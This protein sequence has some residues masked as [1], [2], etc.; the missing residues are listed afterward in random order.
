[1]AESTV[2]IKIQVDADTAAIDRVQARLAALSAQAAATN[3]RLT[4][5]GKTFDNNNKALDKTND[6]LDKTDDRLKKAGK[7]A[8]KFKSALTKLGAILKSITGLLMKG[9]LIN[10]AAVGV[11]IVSVNAAFAV[12]AA[13]VK[14][15]RWSL[16]ALF[17]VLSG[18]GASA[19]AVLSALAAGQREYIAALNASRYGG[20]ASGV[21]NASAQMRG[22]TANTKLAVLGAE[23]L[24]GAFV[25]VSRQTRVTG[26]ITSALT[27]LGDFAASSADPAKSFTA[28]GEFIGQL[29]KEGKLTQQIVEAASEIGPE[30][31]KAVKDA[32]KRG[33]TSSDAFLKALIGGE[34]SKDVAGQLDTINNTLFGTAKRNFQLIKE[35]FA[36]LGQPLL[37]PF[38]EGMER[39]ARIL[40]RSVMQISAATTAFGKGSFFDAMTEGVDKL[41]SWSVKT[42]NEYLPKAE[43]MFGRISKFFRDFQNGWNAALDVIRPLTEGG[44][45]LIDTFGPALSTIFGGFGKGLYEFNDLLKENRD[46]FLEFGEALKTLA[47]EIG[48]LFGVLKKALVDALPTITRVLNLLTEVFAALISVFGGIASMGQFGAVAALAGFGYGYKKLGDIGQTKT[49]KRG[50]GAGRVAAVA[51]LGGNASGGSGLSQSRAPNLPGVT[52]A[53]TVQAKIVYLYGKVIPG[54]GAGPGVGGGGPLPPPAYGGPQYGPPV[55]GPAAQRYARLRAFSGRLAP[56]G[57]MGA[58][59]AMM[60]LPMLADTYSGMGSEGIGNAANL[61]STVGTGSMMMGLG[62][63]KSLGAGGVAYASSLGADYVS[64]LSLGAS[65]GVSGGTFGAIGVGSGAITGA[66][67]GATIGSVVPI[68]G[69]T[70]GAIIGGIAGGITGYMKQGS[71]KKESKQAATDLASNYDEGIKAAFEARDMSAVELYLKQMREDGKLKAAQVPHQESFNKEFEKNAALIEDEMLPKLKMHN[72]NV[73]LLSRSSGVAADKIEQLARDAGVNLVGSLEDVRKTMKQLGIDVAATSEELKHAISTMFGDAVYDALMGPIDAARALE[74]WDQS[75]QVIQDKIKGGISPTD[76]EMSEFLIT[77]YEYLI[78]SGKSQTEALSTLLENTGEGGLFYESG[79]ALS[80]GEAFQEGFTRLLNDVGRK[81]FSEENIKYFVRGGAENLEANYPG[82]FQPVDVDSA[83]RTVQTNLQS[84]IDSGHL[85]RALGAFGELGQLAEPGSIP[86]KQFEALGINL[87]KVNGIFKFGDLAGSYNRFIERF[88]PQNV[89]QGGDTTSSRLASTLGSHDN[90][91]AQLAGK[92]S[93]TS[94]LRDY[95]LGS[96][97]SDHATG[98]AYDLIGQNLGSYQQL[99]QR[100]GGFAEFHGG[101]ANR[102]LHVVPGATGDTNAPIPSLSMMSTP[103]AGMVQ[104]SYQITINP[105]DNAS[106]R[107]IAEMVMDRIIRENRSARER[108]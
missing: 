99:V 74:A 21:A 32:Q 34:L 105:S 63:K 98:N 46:D 51:G 15:Y 38:T 72:D 40:R 56:M 20:G 16:S 27:A 41:M 9:F 42:F 106:P 18:A 49:G 86:V 93:V 14:A 94:S 2:T 92:R 83:S 52:T 107:E 53:M 58:M 59:L 90:F 91:D 67:I 25:S 77:G 10:L 76:A 48:R 35:Q 104:N 4:D 97:S 78:R 103:S 45:V 85:D 87:E 64:G 54:R 71:L 30:F 19:V 75:S 39:V 1:M 33:L 11:A 12:G 84:L 73:K 13:A 68:I 62:V 101:S 6:Q 80:G 69:T 8:D 95:N 50:R 61:A 22:L 96:M 44:S 36:D 37:G 47:E 28:A 66:A 26:Q 29:V 100:S 88:F 57:S 7:S 55:P 23:A 79:M 82:V 31:E 81:L 108:L 3:R 5:M 89:R 43:G 65:R 70:A 60:G 102:H 24:Q 17:Q